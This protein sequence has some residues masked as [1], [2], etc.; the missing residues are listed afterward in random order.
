MRSLATAR[1][2]VLFTVPRLMPSVAAISGSV[3]SSKYLSMTAARIRCGS[4]S[5]A[6]RTTSAISLS[7]EWSAT[8]WS[9]SSSVG[10][11]S[12]R[13]RRHHDMCVLTIAR[14]TYASSAARS[15]IRPHDP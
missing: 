2:T 9:G 12:T 13:R 14:R 5:S 11:S 6:R 10:Y 15:L 7:R 4:R 3:M 1:D 8:T